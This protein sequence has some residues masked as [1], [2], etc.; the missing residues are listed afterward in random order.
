M[1]YFLPDSQDLVDP[2]FDF[3]TE[4]RLAT[5][6]RQRDDL[7]AH[8]VFTERAYDGILVSKGIVDGFGA[9]T[10]R[11]TLAQRQRLLRT[12]APDFF[13]LS[14]VKWG[15]IPMMGDC[16]AFTY[17]KEEKP[18]YTVEDL[19]SFYVECG[20]DYGISLDHVILA[21]QPEWDQTGAL[22][23][24]QERQEL[25]LSLAQNF[26]DLHQRDALPFT[27]LGVAQ[28]W[29]PRSYA[30]S[31]KELQRIGYRYVAVGGMVPLKTHEILA[32]LRE[33]NCVRRDDTRLHLLGIS[34]IETVQDFARLGVASFD[35]TAPLRQAFK[36][37]K[38][39]FYTL[40]R[41]YTAVRIP[42]VEGNPK[43][44]KLISSGK[45]NQERAR[46]LEKACLEA[47]RRFD[48]G[49]VKVDHVLERLSRYEEFYDGEASHQDAYR[50]VLEV[51]P[52]KHC[53][54]DVCRT[55]G[56][57]IILFRGAE[58][59]RRRGFHNTWVFYR[60]LQREL[61]LAAA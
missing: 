48:A 24:M 53:P 34:R 35:S 46:E 4:R 57:H 47:M 44:Q 56:Y 43:L 55:L 15:A 5:R 58:R 2:S 40:Q 25:T 59:N 49:E 26:F 36:D 32:T 42:Q 52:W 61:G 18:P 22:A 6:Q 38:D 11:Y 29:S 19:A 28:G 41:T 9:T 17:V 31:L 7:Y 45:L 3:D 1:R 27:P 50:E 12:G 23:E 51:R 8:E 14:R 16:G 37:G 21:Y 60:R 54:C 13:R 30:R 33:M 10:S 39:N 20:F